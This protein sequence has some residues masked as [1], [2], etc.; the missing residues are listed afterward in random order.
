MLAVNNDGASR[1]SKIELSNVAPLLHERCYMAVVIIWEG[2]A[3]QLPASVVSDFAAHVGFV[4]TSTV[5]CLRFR[6]TSRAALRGL[7]LV[8]LSQSML[9]KDRC[10]LAMAGTAL[11]PLVS[12]FA[13]L[14]SL[15]MA[16]C[17]WH[18]FLRPQ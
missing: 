16:V 13:S 7:A 9:A 12:N 18:G 10:V 3:E 5:S 6:R 11:G 8:K 1:R 14:A 2:C 4:P 15:A 17:I